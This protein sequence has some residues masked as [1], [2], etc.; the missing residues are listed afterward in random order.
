VTLTDHR[1][2]TPPAAAPRRRTKRAVAVVAA[3]AAIAGLV[4]V[5]ALLHPASQPAPAAYD[6]NGPT[7]TVEG[8]ASYVQAVPNDWGAW[9]RLGSLELERGRVTGAPEWYG[10]AEQAFEHSLALHPDG[11]PPALAGEAAI[12]AARHD[13]ST[14]EAQARRALAVNPLD[15][16]AQGVLVDA[17]TEL[18]RYPEALLAAQRLDDTHPGISSY[19]RLAYQEELRGDV[20]Q[21]LAL[22]RLAA[23][24]AANPGQ[25]AFARYQEGVLALQAGD[26]A[27]A[28][29][30][31]DA[32]VAVA[33]ADVTLLHLAAR[34]AV[35]AGDLP[36]AT[37]LF[38]SLV[39]RRPIAAY[40]VEAAQ[41]LTRAG[42]AA[43]ARDLVALA[44]AQLAVSRAGGVN[45]DPNDVVLEATYGSPAVALTMAQALWSR[46]RG[47][48]AA[49]A[50][51]VALHANGRDREALPYAE[52]AL[53]LGTTTPS[54]RVHLDA[55]RAAL[56]AGAK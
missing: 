5:G 28:Q 16:T 14:A 41:V 35:A 24:D 21:A 54:L 29:H 2:T 18:G 38:R 46:Q 13:F 23:D 6:V 37:L 39:E 1:P 45:P 27:E 53:S 7:T 20:P 30:A 50:V 32:G 40:A 22:L 56:R 51:A 48:F 31:Y 33:P 55:V 43:G 42:D 34:L 49:D 47:V 8:L 10:R 19:S 4:G 52:R 3:A 44:Q 36:K 25:V 15:A 26:V 12:S 17:L 9:S 11:N